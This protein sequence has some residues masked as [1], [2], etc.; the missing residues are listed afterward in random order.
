[1]STNIPQR[2]LGRDGPLVPTI[3]LGLMGMH[4]FYGPAQP[5]EQCFKVMDRAIDLGNTFWDT[6]DFYNDNEGMIG[7][8]F[9]SRPGAREKVFLATKFGGYVRLVHPYSNSHILIRL[10]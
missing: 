10:G 4:A 6:S 2:R 5:D 9:K 1:M 8:Y 7:R 3:G